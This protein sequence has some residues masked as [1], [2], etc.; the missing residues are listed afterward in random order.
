MRTEFYLEYLKRRGDSSE[1]WVHLCHGDKS[2]L[3]K[4]QLLGS[5][6]FPKTYGTRTFIIVLRRILLLVIIS[7]INAVYTIHPGSL[8]SILVLFSHPRLGLPSV[9]S[10]SDFPNKTP[11]KA[12]LCSACYIPCLFHPL[13]LDRCILRRVQLMEFLVMHYLPTFSDAIPIRSRYSFQQPV[14]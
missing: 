7:L 14:L 8:R 13:S 10:P 12:I 11:Y 6:I 2:S 1:L 4:Y 3:R 9:H 5:S